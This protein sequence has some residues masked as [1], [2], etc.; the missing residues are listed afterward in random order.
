MVLFDE[1]MHRFLTFQAYVHTHVHTYQYDMSLLP[2]GMSRQFYRRKN[3]IYITYLGL[4]RAQRKIQE[5][6]IRKISNTAKKILYFQYFLDFSFDIFSNK[7][8]KYVI[9][10]EYSISMISSSLFHL[11]YDHMNRL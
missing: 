9:I 1:K 8:L 6:C 4:A 7:I 5:I 10:I 3:R 11:L 2:S